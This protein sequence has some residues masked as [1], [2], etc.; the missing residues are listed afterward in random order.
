[1]KKITAITLHYE[2]GEVIDLSRDDARW[3]FISQKYGFRQVSLS[4]DPLVDAFLLQI[5]QMAVTQ[6]LSTTNKITNL[7][8]VTP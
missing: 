6:A 4:G 8:E 5:L 3:L 1:M 7:S 2:D